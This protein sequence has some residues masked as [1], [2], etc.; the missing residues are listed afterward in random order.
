VP[1][2][3]QSPRQAIARLPACPAPPRR[4]LIALNQL[5]P[6]TTGQSPYFGL[7][8]H[9]SSASGREGKPNAARRPTYHRQRAWGA[10]GGGFQRAAALFDI[11]FLKKRQSRR[12]VRSHREIRAARWPG[13]EFPR[14]R[15]EAKTLLAKT[16]PNSREPGI[17]A[18]VG[19][20]AKCPGPK[21]SRC[22]IRRNS[23][24][25]NEATRPS[26]YP[27]PLRLRSGQEWERGR[28]RKKGL[29]RTVGQSP[30]S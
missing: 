18:V 29:S 6:E 25:E 12:A 1:R 10:S 13:C 8:F 9:A 19:R 2:P 7:R 3:C 28:P 16:K 30:I 23:N 24:I 20:I 26:P 14:F 5:F 27:L 22:V 17:G 4:H 15:R 21:T 11:R